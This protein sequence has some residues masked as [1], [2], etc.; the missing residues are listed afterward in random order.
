MMMLLA[1]AATDI[2]NDA[3]LPAWAPWALM[4][5]VF[6]AVIFLHW[7]KDDPSRLS[8]PVVKIV[9]IAVAITMFITVG[10]VVALIAVVGLFCG[11]AYAT[12]GK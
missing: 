1:E 12:K 6:V 3:P 11:F 4:I 7:V 5:A 2:S 8:N 9:F 10:I